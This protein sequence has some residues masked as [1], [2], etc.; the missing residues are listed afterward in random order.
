MPHQKEAL[1]DHMLTCEFKA[2]TGI[3]CLGCGVQRSFLALIRGDIY[4][5]IVLYPALI[6]F[7]ITILL[8]LYQLRFKKEK[9][10]YVVMYS[11][12]IT[13]GIALVNWGINV[14]SQMMLPTE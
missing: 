5:S 2:H 12:I 10:G 4:Q 3:D 14:Y 11:F 8:L 6:P 13:S 9:G 1:E 7:F